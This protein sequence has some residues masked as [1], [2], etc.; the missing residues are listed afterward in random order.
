MRLVVKCDEKF[1]QRKVDLHAMDWTVMADLIPRHHRFP[2]NGTLEAPLPPVRGFFF[3]R[4]SRGA[5]VLDASD[6]LLI[7]MLTPIGLGGSVT[8]DR[9]VCNCVAPRLILLIF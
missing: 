7:S 3:A 4:W 8:G 6:C 5:A 1:I 2:P 9:V